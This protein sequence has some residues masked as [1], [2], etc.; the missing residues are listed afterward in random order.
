MS[1]LPR[2]SGHQVAAALERAGFQR[3]GGR[4]SHAKYTGPNGE[5]V[6]VPL[7]DELKTGTLSAILR[8]SRLSRDSFLEF[9][10]KA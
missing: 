2:V 6:I 5:K 3:T 9:L 10:R 7:H 1:K 4:G 8:Q